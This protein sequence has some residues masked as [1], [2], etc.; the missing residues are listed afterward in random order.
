MG[1]SLGTRGQ[2]W[3]RVLD[4]V[5]RRP[6]DAANM[7]KRG[8]G[9]QTPMAWS[10]SAVGT[11]PARPWGIQGKGGGGGVG[12]GGGGGGR[13]EEWGGGGG[14]GGPGPPGGLAQAASGTSGGKPGSV[15]CH[16]HSPRGLR[17]GRSTASARRCPRQLPSSARWVLQGKR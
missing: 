5:R 1:A 12:G 14:G 16:S 2:L 7:A 11:Q 10:V 3:W 4:A 9:T 8:G 6:L 15:R 13:R 17:P